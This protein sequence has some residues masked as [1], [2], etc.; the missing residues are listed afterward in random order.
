M[1]LG[2]N[3]TQSSN[4]VSVIIPAYNEESNI[5]T[6]LENVASY[7]SAR[8]YDCEVIVVND[9]SQDAT[10]NQAISRKHLFKDFKILTNKTNRGKGYAVK[11]GILA[12]RG[13]YILFMDADNSTSIDEFDK[14]LPFLQSGYEVVI[15]SRRMRESR[16][17]R[18]QDTR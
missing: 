16:I 12:A 1:I 14:F 2:S 11:R 18:S 8:Q 5:G 7:L 3:M 17:E 15:G 10:S 9:G 13:R 6:T 4:Q